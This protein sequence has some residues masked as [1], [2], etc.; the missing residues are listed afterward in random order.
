MLSYELQNEVIAA[1]VTLPMSSILAVSHKINI[2]KK[3][4]MIV[5][6]KK[7]TLKLQK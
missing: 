4:I 5:I 7:C 2:E 1:I 3:A 6:M